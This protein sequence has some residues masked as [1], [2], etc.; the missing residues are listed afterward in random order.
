MPADCGELIAKAAPEFDP[1]AFHVVEGSCSLRP[2]EGAPTTERTVRV[3]VANENTQGEGRVDVNVS[4]VDLP[5]VPVLVR[6]TTPSIPPGGSAT[7]EGTFRI[8]DIG[9]VPDEFRSNIRASVVPGS[10]VQLGPAE[11][12]DQR[13]RAGASPT[14]NG[15]SPAVADGGM[16][17]PVTTTRVALARACC[18]CA[19]RS[20]RLSG[21]NRRIRDRFDLL[22]AGR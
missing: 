5:N 8:A 19:E 3:A 4:A 18:G 11:R 20:R 10:T 14:S 15:E 12:F 13:V 21:Q 9:T 1:T 17:P 22:T 16:E 7:A 6:L 2:L